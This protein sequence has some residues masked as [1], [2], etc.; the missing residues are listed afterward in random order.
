MVRNKNLWLGACALAIA[1]GISRAGALDG[2]EF[3]VTGGMEDTVRGASLL[4]AQQTDGITDPQEVFTAARADYARILSALYAQ[5]HYSGVIR[6][7]IDG[8]EAADIAPLDAP[9]RIGT[10][11]VIVEPGRKFTFSRTAIAPLAPGTVLPQDFRMGQPAESG[12][13]SQAA[14]AG[15]DGWRNVG[16]AKAAAT[17]QDIVA[18]HAAAQLSADIGLTPGPRLRFGAL[19][20]TGQQ[21]MREARIRK[22]AGLKPGQVYSPAEIDKALN[23]LRR[24]GVF[25]SVAITEADGITPPDLLDLSLAVVEQKTRRYSLG[26]EIASSDGLSLTGYWLHRNLA[27]GGERLKVEAGITNIGAKASGV[28]YY[29]GFTIDRPATFTPDTTAT[30]RFKLAHVDD[31]DY[32][33]NAGDIGL[34]L[35]H[36]FSD[37]LTGRLGIGYTYARGQ[38]PGGRFSFSNLSLPAGLT[39]DT[40]DKATD[41]TRGFYVDVEAK[42]FYGFGT[43]GSGLRATFDARTYRGLGAENRVVLAARLQGG[44]VFGPTLL[45]TPR[46]DLFFSGGGGT[47]RGQPYRSLGVS[48][49]RGFGPAFKI[50]GQYFLGAS[51]EVRAKVTRNIGVVGFADAG[52]IGIDTGTG[53]MSDWHAG[54]GLGVRYDTSIGPI[55]LDV[56]VPVR[57]TTGDG[58]QIY[59]GL[60]QAF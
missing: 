17:R 29:G 12:L 56:A 25:S 8:R 42:P 2:V 33:A 39:W 52:A 45:E 44:A 19:E 21:R 24:T 41:A 30:L 60:G 10:V 32:F 57:G 34:S 1:L 36:I 31:E 26:A 5:G 27:G 16:H 40:R 18:D 7:L 47:V 6:I 51:A 37:R 22:I 38:D 20:I 13:I 59:I 49:T 23:R 46:G 43:T 35:S 3:R 58:M 28:D 55:R 15:I 48:V 50:G 4:A 53:I 9:A 11:Q 14:T 54:A